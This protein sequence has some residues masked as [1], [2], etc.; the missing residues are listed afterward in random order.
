[1]ELMI[2]FVQSPI[3]DE[4]PHQ[5][6]NYESKLTEQGTSSPGWKTAIYSQVINNARSLAPEVRHYVTTHLIFL[7]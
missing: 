2:F 5:K 4:I 7:S 6:L 1:M 3:C